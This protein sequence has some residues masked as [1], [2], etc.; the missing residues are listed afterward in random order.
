M[1][2]Q[3]Q[4]SGVGL[5]YCVL[6]STF[7]ALSLSKGA[8]YVLYSD[9]PLLHSVFCILVF[10]LPL[11]LGLWTAFPA[12]RPSPSALPFL[13]APGYW[14]HCIDIPVSKAYSSP[15]NHDFT[16]MKG[17]VPV[18]I[19]VPSDPEVVKA[20]KP[21][22]QG[23][24][25]WSRFTEPWYGRACPPKPGTHQAFSGQRPGVGGTGRARYSARGVRSHK[26]C[27]RATGV[28]PRKNPSLEGR[29]F[30]LELRITDYGLRIE[31]IHN[32]KS[33]N[34]NVSIS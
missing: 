30:Y 6:H 1:S 25:P 29:I 17:T 10:P 18:L 12:L 11:D 15:L 7:P 14:V 16:A 3:K 20:R 2:N 4:G 31:K 21:R 22:G 9:V 13:L 28:V 24:S 32:S 19:Q 23:R 34:R 5:F 33:S 26:Q 8:F 27:A